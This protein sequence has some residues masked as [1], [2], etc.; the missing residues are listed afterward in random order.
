MH[1]TTV[2]GKVGR[3]DFLQTAG[4]A[5]AAAL[6]GSQAQAQTGKRPPDHGPKVPATTVRSV[7]RF[8]GSDIDYAYAVKAGPWL[9]LTGHEGF[10]FEKGL[11]ADV[12]GPAAFP[13]Y[14]TPP[15][16][17]EADYLV[18]RMRAILRDFGSDLQNTVR[19]DQ[20]YTSFRAVTAYHETRNAEFG[21]YVP[22]STSVLMERC[23]GAHS[24][25]SNSLI[26]TVGEDLA[27][28]PF[29]PTGLTAPG[30]SSYS[31][32]VACG[33][34]L[35]VAGN[36]ATG[37]DGGLSTE[38][39]PRPDRNWGRPVLIQLQAEYI[40]TKR[41]EPILQAAGA[42]LSNCVKAQV[43]I[44]RASNFADFMAVWMRHFR[45]IPCALTVVTGKGWG[46]TDAII[47]INIIA[48]K[49]GALGKKQVVKVD[50]PEMAT[51]GPCVRAGDLVFPSGLMA[52]GK[53]GAVAGVESAN[54][55]EGLNLAG[56]LQ[57]S[58]I[59]DYADAVCSA[60][61]VTMKNVAR[62]QYFMADIRDFAGLARSWANKFQGVPHPFVCV[63]A[64]A[65]LFAAG[66]AVVAD[67]W[68]YAG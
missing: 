20:Y 50:L 13:N 46:A 49:D 17:R 1:N 38:A 61:G 60:V 27:I 22:P 2:T 51:F 40:I 19:V 66:A 36:M 7:K 35:F 3:R 30:D 21:K 65:P 41:L 52:I 31:P 18:R 48:L 45:D 56:Y 25:I 6:L 9:F 44:D 32:I 57:G 55:F 64:P 28:Q 39:R 37:A 67:F 43:Y 54:V 63:Q 29:Y 53:D 24:N 42:K 12:E 62:A 14:G 8:L 59:H 15:L 34:L 16:R 4:M 11:L 68:I 26:A 10:D 5:G 58:L 23:F 47:E 33:D